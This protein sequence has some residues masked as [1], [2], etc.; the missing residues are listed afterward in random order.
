MA[1]FCKEC[2]APLPENS[3]FCPKCGKP[4]THLGGASVGLKII[5]LLIPLAGWIMYFIFKEEN[6]IAK[7]RDCSKYAW[8]GFGIDFVFGFIGGLGAA[9]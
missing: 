3:T 7:A 9:L 6:N 5:S 2:G 1:Q 8:I 4:T